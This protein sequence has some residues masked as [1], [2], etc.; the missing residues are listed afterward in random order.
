MQTAPKVLIKSPPH[1]W[2]V[3]ETGM[4]TALAVALALTALLALAGSG[5]ELW[6]GFHRWDSPEM[7][8]RTID[9]L[10]LAL[11]LVEILHT[12]RISIRSH[13]LVAEPF[14]FLSLA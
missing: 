13:A 9:H 4:Y 3:V 8:L 1:F 14:L 11:M 5:F 6:K 7:I 2:S 12:V 10:L